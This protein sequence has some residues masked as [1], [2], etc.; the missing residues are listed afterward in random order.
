MVYGSGEA[1]VILTKEQAATLRA[2]GLEEYSA[3]KG[4]LLATTAGLV[5][6]GSGAMYLAAGLPLCLPFGGGGLLG[7]LYQWMLQQGVDAMPVDAGVDDEAGQYGNPL[8]NPLVRLASVLG[9]GYLLWVGQQAV[10][11]YADPVGQVDDL[12]KILAGLAGFL[13]YK[14]AVVSVTVLP[15]KAREPV[16]PK[17]RHGG[18]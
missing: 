17:H 9:L 2:L 12:P 10:G 8:S 7:L 15:A 1:A 18:L 13:M 6:L 14:L 11:Q 4:R 3:L 16:M 5:G